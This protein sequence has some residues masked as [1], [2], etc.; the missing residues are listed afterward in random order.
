MRRLVA[1]GGDQTL[2][3]ERPARST[4]RL[5]SPDNGVVLP[6]RISPNRPVLPKTSYNQ[7]N[8]MKYFAFARTLR[9]L[10][11]VLVMA[12]LAPLAFGGDPSPSSVT[13]S[14]AEAPATR[15]LTLKECLDEALRNNHRRPASKYAVLMAEAQH[16]QALAGYWPQ[17][18]AKGGYE[19]LNDAP[20]FI[21]PP[22]A[23]SLPAQAISLPPGLSIPVDGPGGT[24]V[25][26]LKSIPVPAQTINIPAQDVKLM[27]AGT[28]A[29]SLQG[30]W[31]LYDGGMRKGLGEQSKG[32]VDIMKE[33]A[34]RTD[35]EIV[36]SVKRFYYGSVL[37]RQIRQ[38]GEDTLA[39]MET[40]LSLTETMYKEGS[41]KVKKT[42][43]LD[44]KVM[45]ETLRAMV[46]LLEKN[47]EMAQAALANT[48]GLT[49]QTSVRAAD[50]S[51]P[52][53][54]FA[55]NLA[56]MVGAAYKFNPDWA[57]IEA[58]IRAAEGAVREAKSG[59]SPKL[60]L[61]GELHRYWNDYQSGLSTDNNKEGWSVDA[62]VQIPLFSGFLTKNKVAETRAR[63]AKIKEEQFLLKDGLGLQVKDAFLGL[64][65]AQKSH[66]ATLDAM[67]AATE[68]RD[69]NTRAYQSELVE[70]EKVIR[71][72]LMEALMS[73]QHYKACFDQVALRSQLDLL[74]G[75]EILRRFQP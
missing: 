17:I 69:L 64:V 16:R 23:F 2:E 1:A 54:P 36:D 52:F 73:A 25:G 70:T 74:V 49:W 13:P 26:S 37:A 45:V 31:L 18:S 28:F 48:M 6:P 68:N 55:D 72:Q 34:R 39:R 61:T 75:K 60:A 57:K 29:T 71:A 41:G 63:L 65:A 56:S 3:D 11:V 44:N 51:I 15:E 24:Q 22:S 33:E 59:Y 35:L 43:W 46:A 66:Q 62:G 27:D 58:G 10:C 12:L 42:D 14:P 19:R 8:R 53:T 40:T 21:F 67:N 20:N 32:L 5:P 50:K 7:T 38:V 4:A 30:T 47:D 9:S